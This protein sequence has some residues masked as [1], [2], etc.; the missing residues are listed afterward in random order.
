TS[1]TEKP[2]KSTVCGAFSYPGRNANRA[3][4]CTI[5]HCLVVKMV[6]RKSRP[7]FL[8]KETSGKDTGGTL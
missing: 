3:F 4:S 6:V 2:C 5:V 1:T 7:Y 8:K